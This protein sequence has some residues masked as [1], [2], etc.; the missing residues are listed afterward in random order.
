MRRK[1][2]TTYAT[3][4]ALTLTGGAMAAGEKQGEQQQPSEQQQGA[5]PAQGAQQEQGAPPEQGAQQEQG[6]EKQ[7]SAQKEEGAQKKGT[8]KK[9]SMKLDPEQAKALQRK[10]Q[11]TGDYMG[12]IDGIVGP[13]TTAALRD[14]QSENDLAVTGMLNDETRQALGLAE[15]AE[16]T[17]PTAGTEEEMEAGAAEE[18]EKEPAA[19][20]EATETA[21]GTEGIQLS[22][23]DEEQVRA[24][25]TKLQELGYYRAKI[26]GIVGP[27][28]RA[29]LQQFYRKNAQL[30][31]RGMITEDGASAF[32]LD[33]SEM[34]PVR[35]KEEEP[36]KTEEQPEQEPPSGTEPQPPTGESGGEQQAPMEQQGPPS[37]SDQPGEEQQRQGEGTPPY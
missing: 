37:G 6:A 21:V 14:F 32:G 5:P 22:A 24:L 20:R 30:A 9:A 33:V 7:E 18:P 26:D 12:N 4:L 29:A 34:E 17:E 8:Q 23:I 27:K 10:L 13:Q 35:G 11:D 15:G 16:E 28:T 19:K 2:A 31:A 36:S 1:A 3:A 25:Q